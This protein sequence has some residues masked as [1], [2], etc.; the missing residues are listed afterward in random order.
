MKKTESPVSNGVRGGSYKTTER[1]R[2]LAS[3]TETGFDFL[4]NANRGFRAVLNP[5]R[6]R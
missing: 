2:F 5:R 4:P 3:H 1:F 6:A